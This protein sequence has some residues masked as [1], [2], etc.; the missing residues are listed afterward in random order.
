MATTCNEKVQ[1]PHTRYLAE[2][3]VLHTLVTPRLLHSL[4]YHPI[5]SPPILGQ[6]QLYVGVHGRQDTMSMLHDELSQDCCDICFLTATDSGTNFIAVDPDAEELVCR[7]I[8]M[9]ARNS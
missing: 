1:R 2:L 6:G 5:P 3:Q 9:P 8:G 4:W 7:G